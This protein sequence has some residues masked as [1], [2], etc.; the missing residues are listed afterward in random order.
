[1]VRHTR[2]SQNDFTPQSLFTINISTVLN[3]QNYEIVIFYVEENPIVSNPKS[4]L[5]IRWF[6]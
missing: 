5:G 6:S 4:I 3:I 2:R 1:M